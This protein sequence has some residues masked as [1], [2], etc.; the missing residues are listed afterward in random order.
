MLGLH[1]LLWLHHLLLLLHLHLHSLLYLL[2]NSVIVHL[3]RESQSL[4]HRIHLRL[5]G[6]LRHPVKRSH[7][8]LGLQLDFVGVKSVG[9]VLIHC[10]FL[11]DWLSHHLRQVGDL[12]VLDQHR[13]LE[14]VELVGDCGILA[15]EGEAA[16][17]ENRGEGAVVDLVHLLLVVGDSIT[18]AAITV[19]SV[20]SAPDVSVSSAAEPASS[21]PAGPEPAPSV[22]AVTM[23]DGRAFVEA[24]SEAVSVT[25]AVTVAVTVRFYA[26]RFYAV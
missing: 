18:G 19:A 12:L 15:V 4:K 11:V 26:V 16:V 20:S 22:A 7:I 10:H 17:D 1:H 5:L 6:C 3:R 23:V 2:H 8:R 24:F 14:R 13:G 9:E 21:E 25:V